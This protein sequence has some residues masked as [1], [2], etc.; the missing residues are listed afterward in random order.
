MIV[1]QHGF[2]GKVSQRHEFDFQLELLDTNGLKYTGPYVYWATKRALGRFNPDLVIL[3]YANL[4]KPYLI[5]ASRG[6]PIITIQDPYQLICPIDVGLLF[7]N[8][9][10]CQF[11]AIRNPG[12]C[13]LCPD[14]ITRI[15]KGIGPIA[16]PEYFRSFRFLYPLYHKLLLKS[17][18]MPLRYVVGST[19]VKAR[20]AEIIPEKLITIIPFGVNPQVFRPTEKSAQKPIRIYLPGRMWDPVKGM[21]VMLQAAN[22]LWREGYRFELIVRGAVPSNID[23]R[24]YPFLK[25]LEW[26]SDKAP[27]ETYAMSDIVAVP[28]LFAE[29]FGLVAVEAMSC[30]L[31]VVASGHG[32]LIDTVVDG[33]T[34]YLFKPGDSDDLTL[35]LK[36]LLVDADLRSAMGKK[37]RSRVLENYTWDRVVLQYD[38]LI[39]NVFDQNTNPGHIPTYQ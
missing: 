30:G 14:N 2:R 26:G 9:K 34:G 29:P 39:K 21:G 36:Q 6:Y 15:V 8:G 27:A 38:A 1:P 24:K 12:Q 23:D 13:A 31:P 3:A 25:R 19:Y 35:K 18:T 33:T 32:G 4:F 11:D 28:S 5:H 7:R 22:K 16:G 17:L 20:C 10:V 37:G